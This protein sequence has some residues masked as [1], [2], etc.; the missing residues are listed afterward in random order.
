M[1][2][3]DFQMPGMD[4]PEGQGLLSAAFS[5]LQARKMPGERGLGGALGAA[6]QQY[7]QTRT[8]AMDAA[9]KRKYLDA[10]MAA[11]Q[12]EQEIRQAQLKA[13]QAKAA[14]DA[15]KAAEDARIRGLV[16]NAGAVRPGMGAGLPD[17]TLPPEFSTG[18][19]FPALQQPGQIDY[20]SLYR[21][22]VPLDMLKGLAETST[23][24]KPKVKN[25]ETVSVNGKPM[26]VGIDE[27]GQQVAQ[28]GMEWKP[29]QFQD[30]GGD[31]RAFDQ[32]NPQAG[33]TKVGDKSM[34]FS[35][36]IAQGQLGVSQANLGLARQRLQFDQTQGG[37]KAPAGY[38]FTADGKALEAI[39][40]GP[41]D[42]K[43]GELGAKADARRSSQMV[44]AQSVLDTIKDA[45]SLVGYNTAGFGGMAASI[46]MTDA[47]DLSAKLETVKANLGFDRLQ[48]M[49]EQSPTGGALGAVAVQ[50]LTA[51]QSTVASLDQLQ[52]PE[53]LRAA[54]NKIENHYTRWM[55]VMKQADGGKGG[56]QGSWESP[57]KA[58]WVYKNG[59]LVKAD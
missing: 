20:Q 10:Q 5:L 33:F 34:T 30:F 11:Q 38:R 37:A 49:R 8:G 55:D 44:Q 41:A 50:E 31:I 12:T 57:K 46:P 3:F 17:G 29:L 9:Q 13:A 4:T 25:I 56:A 47:R 59:K 16:A 6:G 28:I 14:E 53:Q 48:Q 42:I 21:Q 51:L 7:M 58:D 1:S 40:G 35:D 36:K 24:G 39:P 2:L 52:K 23:L 45:K 22:G 15:R 54:L 43:A 26:K 18:Q 32:T 27:F 19:T